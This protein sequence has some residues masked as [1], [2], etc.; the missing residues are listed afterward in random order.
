MACESMSTLEILVRMDKLAKRG[1]KGLVRWANYHLELVRRGIL[2][3]KL[4]FAG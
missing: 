1:R 4:T 2:I 3:P